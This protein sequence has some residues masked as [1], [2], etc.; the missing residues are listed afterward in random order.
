MVLRA[1]VL[2][3]LA[4]GAAAA[5]PYSHRWDTVADL[6]GMHG[7]YGNTRPSASSIA[8]AAEHYSTITLGGGCRR[9]NFTYTMEMDC[10]ATAVE[11]K[12]ADAG[13]LTGMYWRSDFA[14]EI[15]ECSGFSAEWN[16]H[17]EYRL[18]M[19]N[20]SYVANGDPSHGIFYID[21]SNKEAAAFFAKV[22]VNV[23]KALLPSG[24]PV[25]DYLYIDGDPLLGQGFPGVSAQ[26]SALLVQAY[27]NCFGDIQRQLDAAG[28]E[29][30]VILNGL[31]EA[32]SAAFHVGSGCAGSMFDH[33]SI[34]QFLDSATGE[35]SFA[36][37]EQGFAM[38]MGPLQFRARPLPAGGARHRLL[39]VQLVL[40]LG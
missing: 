30:R 27:Y 7:S 20:G 32:S 15:A 2:T 6:M 26:R 21:Y 14:L 33:W 10:L 12:A 28:H 13:T 31:D 36:T 34:L 19:D 1:A 37:M 29:Q 22:L 17:P 24:R 39:G 4:A 18:K 23:T 35:F 9:G 25:F 16:A 38:V 3:T 8:F 11:I 40:G 5:K